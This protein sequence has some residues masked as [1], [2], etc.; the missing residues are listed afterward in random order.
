MCP[1]LGRSQCHDQHRPR[2]QCNSAL[3]LTS[4]ATVHS[5]KAGPPLFKQ[6]VPHPASCQPTTNSLQSGSLCSLECVYTEPSP[7]HIP[8]SKG[9]ERSSDSSSQHTALSCSV[10]SPAA[11]SCTTSGGEKAAR[12]FG[13]SRPWG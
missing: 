11:L 2:L 13:Y 6:T 7:C 4:Q 3:N 1:V 12:V 8:T 10:S 9:S 5:A